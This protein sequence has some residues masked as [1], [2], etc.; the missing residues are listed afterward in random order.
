MK[1][2]AC[3]LIMLCTVLCALSFSASAEGENEDLQSFG[4][5]IIR[6]EGDSYTLSLIDGTYSSTADT[7]TECFSL[8]PSEATVIL[9]NI[10]TDKPP[11]LPEGRYTLVGSLSVTD[12]IFTVPEGC[13]LNLDSLT[14]DFSESSASYMRIKGGSVT[15]RDSTLFGSLSGAVLL[16]YLSSSELTVYSGKISSESDFAAVRAEVGTLCASGGSIINRRGSAVSCSATLLL[17]GSPEIS[18]VGYDIVTDRPLTLSAGGVGYSSTEELSVMLSDVFRVGTLTEVLYSSDKERAAAVRI[19]DREGREYGLT[20]FASSPYSDEKNFSAVYLPYKIT[21]YGRSGV[22]RTDEALSGEILSAPTAPEIKGYNFSGYYTDSECSHAYP[23][24][25]P[26]TS[27]LSL[28]AGYRLKPPTLKISSYSADYNGA[29]HYLAPDTLNH[30]LLSEGGFFG[31]RWYKDGEVVSYD[32]SLELYRHSDSGVYSLEVTFYYSSDSVTVR[33]EN[34]SFIINK[35]KVPL[36]TVEPKYYNGENQSPLIQK[37]PYYSVSRVSATNVGVYPVELILL[38]PENYAFEGSSERRVSVPFEILKAENSWTVLPSASDIYEGQSPAPEAYSAFGEVVFLYSPSLGGEYLPT[39]PSGVGARFMI[40]SVEESENYTGLVSEPVEFRVLEERLLSLTVKSS[41]ER[42]SYTAFEEFDGTGLLIIA[43]YSG[44]REEEL[45]FDELN[46]SYQRGDT[47][48][49]GD[50]AVNLGYGGKSC[51]ISVSVSAAE[52]DLTGLSLSDLVLVYNGSYRTLTPA[53]SEIVGKD[54]YP[55]NVEINGGGTDVGVYNITVDFYTQSTSYKKPSS[56]NYTLE[57]KPLSVEALWGRGEFVYD[58]TAKCPTAT[59]VDSLGVSRALT[60]LGAKTDAG[61]VYTATAESYSSNYVITNPTID[62]RIKRADYDLS[63]VTF[64]PSSFVYDGEEKEVYVQNLPDGL[65]AVGYTDGSATE[66]GSYTA[67]VIFSYDEKNYNPPKALSLV[68]TIHKADYDISGIRFEDT[69]VVF[70]GVAH[71]PSVVGEMPVGAD[72][73]PL[74]YRIEGSATHVSDGACEVK[75]VFVSNSPNYRAPAPLS[76]L[77]RVLPKSVAVIWEID[78]YTFNGREQLPSARSLECE[79]E[80]SGAAVN[81]G[82][83]T[84]TARA[85]SPDYRVT[86]PEA[87][88]EI[89]KAENRWIELPKIGDF[90]S[91]KSP[92]PTASAYFGEPIFGYYAD[93]ACSLSAPLPL[94]AGSYYMRASVPESENYL[95]LEYAPVAFSVLEVVLIDLRVSLNNGTLVAHSPLTDSDFLAVAKY[96]DGRE[97]PLTL[98]D[99]TVSYDGK[100]LPERGDSEISVSYG[101]ITITLPVSVGYADYD[102]SGVR[103]Q[104]TVTEYNGTPQSPSL[105]GLPEGVSVVGYEGAERTAAGRYTVKAQVLY[106]TKNYN[107]PTLPPCEFVINKAAVTPTVPVP[108]VYDGR[109]KQPESGSPLYTFLYEGEILDAGEYLLKLQLTD[110]DNYKLEADSLTYKVLPR[111]LSVTVGDISRYLGGECDEADLCITDGA[112]VEGDELTYTQIIRDGRVYLVSTN[113]NYE[114]SSVS[115]SVTERPYPSPRV[116]R[117]ILL[118]VFSLAVFVLLLLLAIRGRE[119][120][121][122][123]VAAASCKWHNRR[124][125][126]PH[127]RTLS[128]YPEEYSARPDLPKK[129][130]ADNLSL[131]K[132]E[133]LAE[134]SEN[135]YTEVYPTELVDE[136]ERKNSDENKVTGEAHGEALDDP[137]LFA[138]HHIGEALGALSVDMERAD[139]LISDSLAK[140]LVKKSRE[141]VITGGYQKGI[142]NVDTLSESFCDGERV[143]INIL[144]SRGLLADNT[145]YLKVLARGS[146]DKPLS[147]YANDFSLSAVKM[148]ALTGGEAVKVVTVKKNTRDFPYNT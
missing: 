119:S 61:E 60:V 84:A 95:S 104:N 67:T 101:G 41:P 137:D 56:Q 9:E 72:G 126:I 85:L 54:G 135:P 75:L 83:Y 43:S 87:D 142:I 98:S 99:L 71:T 51:R 28:F 21:Y 4:E 25:E 31:Y 78:R 103:W 130:K 22:F 30:E 125:K 145:A 129:D 136:E 143:D 63:G 44:G 17:S 53:I 81:A 122:A 3:V 59:F 14:L 105:S 94:S 69:E 82:K 1:R 111:R 127:P 121:R 20:H 91:S 147:V 148:I 65:V 116:T 76:A 112:L 113:P 102:L 128:S 115:G 37:S 140:E 64:S 34:V 18:G 86:N 62:F 8:L 16:D 92:A 6:N 23:F 134:K 2:L 146:I 74:S 68:W 39:L 42:L 49:Y 5:Y 19:F 35:A 141:S 57:I 89:F 120:I 107:A 133:A 40:A 93:E 29:A 77:V 108:S 38:D 131:S 11:E 109:A 70:D 48:L 12:G 36:P 106:D 47:F 27:D 33:A 144:K 80:V 46:V 73:I 79:I 66:A 118:S 139:E 97:I 114:L 58:G 123:G 96:N 100:A 90:Y 52:Y 13:I 138:S 124:L 10:S 50:N 110:P 15:L 24:G 7:L 26:V 32:E 55:L 117:I 88:F 132:T 45:T